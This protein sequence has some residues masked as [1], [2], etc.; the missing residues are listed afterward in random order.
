MKAAFLLIALFYV[1]AAEHCRA[2][3]AAFGAAAFIS[4][5]M[6]AVV[7]GIQAEN[8]AEVA[9]I[10]A[11]A[12]MDMTDTVAQ[13]S[14][15]LATIAQG[16]SMYQTYMSMVAN[17]INQAAATTRLGMQLATL[18]KIMSMTMDMKQT[19]F[20]AEFSLKKAMLDLQERQLGANVALAQSKQNYD[21]MKAGLSQGNAPSDSGSGLAVSTSGIATDHPVDNGD[22]NGDGATMRAFASYPA[23]AAGTPAS[24][25]GKLL[26][27]LSVEEDSAGA[28]S[29]SLSKTS[30][31]ISIA[32]SGDGAG[33]DAKAFLPAEPR[34]IRTINAYGENGGAS[35]GN[36]N[37]EPDTKGAVAV[38]YQYAD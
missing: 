3:S 16:T 31:P 36:S 17:S 12:E 27:S 14:V 33:S 29:P 18:D 10:N 26:N 7:G 9:R 23:S 22:D 8:D 28:Q 2:E 34:A 38:P 24:A 37:T 35:R 15:A 5:S 19:Q 11:E 20:M 25:S 21:L 30:Q 13:N 1:S 4:A 32:A 6:P